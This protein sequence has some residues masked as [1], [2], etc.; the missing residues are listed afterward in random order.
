MSNNI[1]S[2]RKSYGLLIA[3]AVVFSG[4]FTTTGFAKDGVV[5]VLGPIKTLPSSGFVGNWVIGTRTVKVDS[6]TV[7]KQEIGLAKVGAVVEAK[8]TPQSDGSLLATKIEVQTAGAAGGG[9]LMI[10]GLINALP[11]GNRVGE[12][13]VSNRKITVT[14][15]TLLDQTRGAFAVG[16]RVEIEGFLQTDGT[17]SASK[18]KT[19]PEDPPGS[20]GEDFKFFGTIGKLPGTANFVGDWTVSGRIVHVTAATQL[21]QERSRIALG[22]YVSVE[23]LPQADGSVTATEIKTIIVATASSA[24]YYANRVSP[25]AIAAGFGSLLSIGL[26]VATTLPLP[27]TLNGT[28]VRISD[29]LCN[30]REAP[31]FF[32]SPNQVNYQIPAS[33]APGAARVSISNSNGD[34]ITGD[35]SIERTAPGLFS[36]N[37]TGAGYAA[38]Y[39]LRVKS[40]GAQQTEAIAVYDDNLKQFV[41]RA[42]DVSSDDVFLVLFGTGLRY[43]SGLSSISA[44]VG[45]AS[46]PVLYAGAQGSLSGL[47]QVNL[48]L[49]RNLAG[50]G[51]IEV[52]FEAEGKKT[53]RVKV[54]IR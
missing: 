28:N 53:N 46:A 19:R 23:A 45:G 40:N 42:I 16:V 37:A 10:H 47:D 24:S 21:E 33:L 7:I 18:I 34:L 26:Q 20:I 35:L 6:A 5:E 30:E 48:R 41:G 9:Y 54:H 38:A 43:H 4:L 52:E 15:A 17:I 11:G 27:T 3:L 39:V 22:V 1:Q 29:S 49:N 2:T 44:T 12:W 14:T 25:D 13:T 51:E 50:R 31:L 8:A 36:A 32:V